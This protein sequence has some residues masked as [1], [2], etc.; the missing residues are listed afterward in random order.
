MESNRIHT[1]EDDLE[2]QQAEGGESKDNYYKTNFN[3]FYGSKY[4]ES[5]LVT[6][7]I[8]RVTGLKTINIAIKYKIILI[9]IYSTGKSS[10]AERFIIDTF[11]KDKN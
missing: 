8:K 2:T 6:S 5:Q 9:G 7:G 3:E 4:K 10:L 1:E 11:K